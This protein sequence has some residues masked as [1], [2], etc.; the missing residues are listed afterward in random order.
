VGTRNSPCST[1]NFAHFSSIK[2]GSYAFG[3]SELI[4]LKRSRGAG[5]I[6]KERSENRKQKTENRK[7]R[8]ENRDQRITTCRKSES[9]KRGPL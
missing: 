7:E 9:P 1:Q 5:E 6:R 4:S 3:S 2:E 8:S